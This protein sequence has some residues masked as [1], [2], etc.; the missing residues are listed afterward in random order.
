MATLF[1]YIATD[2]VKNAQLSIK[3]KILK[4]ICL[5]EAGF[6]SES[7]KYL[8]KVAFE[9]DLPIIWLE[10]SDYLKKEK[11]MNWV[12]EGQLYNNNEF[13]INAENKAVIEEF[14]KLALNPTSSALFGIINPVL[15][16]YAKSYTL[17]KIF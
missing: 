6:I 10:S 4:A 17:F 11:G 2:V 13:W 14:K 5:A 15:F 16:S 12:Q 1:D 9:K 3:A 7:M 8:T